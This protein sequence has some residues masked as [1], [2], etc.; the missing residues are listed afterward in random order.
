MSTSLP[1][2]GAAGGAP[3]GAGALAH[4]RH[5][6]GGG[7]RRARGDLAARD[8][9]HSA[10][11]LDTTATPNLVRLDVSGSGDYA[12]NNF[13]FGSPSLDDTGTPAHASRM[14]FD[15]STGAFRAGSA[16]GTQWDTRGLYGFATGL[17]NT[18]SSTTSAAIGGSNNACSS[19]GSVAIGGRNNTISGAGGSGF[20]IAS[21]QCAI[22]NVNRSGALASQGATI[23]GNYSNAIAIASNGA[24]I[25]ANYG[26]TRG[27]D[28][29]ADSNTK[30][31]H[32][33]GQ[34]Q[35]RDAGS[36]QG[37]VYVGKGRSTNNVVDIFDSIGA[38]FTIPNNT[39]YALDIDVVLV[40]RVGE[41]NAVK[42]GGEKACAVIKTNSAGAVTI[43]NAGLVYGYLAGATISIQSSGN[44]QWF[45]RVR[46]S[47]V[48]F[49][50]EAVAHIKSVEIQAN[51]SHLNSASVHAPLIL[52]PI[53]P[54]LN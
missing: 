3:S 54:I 9:V 26:M 14:L 50:I 4:G 48:R 15:K 23:N 5:L 51:L 1:A 29:L 39:V 35:N 37:G 7:R 42:Y 24:S 16:T 34:M 49:Y 32:G 2:T 45:V 44:N 12:T 17:N 19:E 46:F 53:P 28:P 36:A 38:P 8:P 18:C 25:T 20:A 21:N 13:V 11:T 40:D 30:L 47:T 52:D 6:V 27:L 33:A 43:N 22:T 31:V 41:G 10:F